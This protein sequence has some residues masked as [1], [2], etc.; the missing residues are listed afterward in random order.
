M[1]GMT[2]RLKEEFSNRSGAALL[3]GEDQLPYTVN[4][5]KTLHLIIWS[6][7]IMGKVRKILSMA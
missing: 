7:S 2:D 1:I 6:K 5:S 4:F 3:D